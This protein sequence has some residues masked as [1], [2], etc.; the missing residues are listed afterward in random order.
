MVLGD[1]DDSDD[2]VGVDESLEVELEPLPLPV[3]SMVIDA[4]LGALVAVDLP[5]VA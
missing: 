2:A 1:D 5:I 4:R 3:A